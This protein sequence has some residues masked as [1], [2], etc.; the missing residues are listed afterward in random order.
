MSDKIRAGDMVSVNFHSAQMTLFYKGEVLCVPCE[1][2]DSWAF[3]DD[4]GAI[5]YV[6][7][8]CTITKLAE[9]RG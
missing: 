9:E 5:H 1:I 3:K 6:S 8:G 2:G 7:E 4:N